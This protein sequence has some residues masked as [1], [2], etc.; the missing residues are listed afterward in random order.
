MKKF[1]KIGALLFLSAYLFIGLNLASPVLAADEVKF[2]PQIGIP[3]S[4]FQQGVSTTVGT[5]SSTT[6]TSDLLARYVAAFYKWGLSIVGVLAVL[7]LMAGGLMWLSSGG[8]SGRIGSAKKMI[9]GSLLGTFLL[10]GAYFFLNT[11]NPDLTKL[12]VLTIETVKKVAE[13]ELICCDPTK[14][15]TRIPIKIVD[16]KNIATNGALIGKEVTCGNNVSICYSGDACLKD[17]SPT[18]P[19]YKCFTDNWSC[20]CKVPGIVADYTN[21]CQD[22]TTK[23]GCNSWCKDKANFIS[24]YQTFITAASTNQCY[25]DNLSYPKPGA[26]C[27]SRPSATCRP[28]GDLAKDALKCPDGS[29]HDWL[30]AESCAPGY[31]C[32][33]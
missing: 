30:G 8:D 7:M 9:E 11:I 17:S 32:C 2:T 6:A 10:L 12:P 26:S 31:F 1:K 13:S 16:G 21:Y 24:G 23:E 14:G 15:E 33:Y 19:K 27:G 25:S 29:S 3:G 28:K 18:D 22:N 4:E 5:I 20:V